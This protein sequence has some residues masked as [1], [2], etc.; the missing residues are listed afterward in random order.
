M[1]TSFR[2]TNGSNQSCFSS[3][4]PI[5]LPQIERY[6]PSILAEGAHDSKG[7][8]YSFVPTIQV[9]NGLAKEGFDPFEVRQTRCR[10]ESKR[11]F[12]KHLVRLRKR[13]VDMS[14]GEAPEIVLLNSHD[15]SSSYHLM[16]GMFRMIC[17]NGL[18]SGNIQDDIKVRHSGRIVDDVIEGAFR[19]LDNIALL[20]DN[21]EAFKEIDVTPA[22]QSLLAETAAEIRWGTDDSGTVLSPL[23][24]NTHLLRP[25]RWADNKNDLWTVFNRI[26]ENTL[27]G[28]LYGRSATGRNTRTREVVGVTENVRLNRSLWSMAEKFAELKLA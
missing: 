28:G 6:A 19:V 4:T 10:D 9:L 3:R 2:Y 27:R 26:Q 25:R 21:V 8:R 13:G 17:S 7:P 18:I 5:T 16:S 15:G 1:E 11:S 20:E 14:S 24:S 12:T 22:E 23:T